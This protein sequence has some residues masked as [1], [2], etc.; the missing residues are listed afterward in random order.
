EFSKE[1]ALCLAANGIKAYRFES[2]RPTPE[3][4]F[5]VR[6]L[7]CI[8]GIVITASHN[9]KNHNGLKISKNNAEPVGYNTGL[10]DLEHWV[11]T[12][13]IA[14]TNKKGKIE[15]YN[16]MTEY[17][18]FLLSYKPDFDNLNIVVDC[19]NGMAS[20]LVDKILGEKPHYIN[21][22]MD[23]NFPG[24]EPN[25]LEMENI[26]QLQTAVQH[27]RADIGV[28]F[29]GDADRVMFVDENAQ[30]ISPDLMI[31]L[32]GHY[33]YEQKKLSGKVLFDIRTS[34]AVKEYLTQMGGEPHMWKVGRAYA[35]SKLKE[36]DGLFGGELA[37]HYY[38]KDFFYSDSAMLAVIL[39]LNIVAD[40][41]RK[42]I[43]VSQ[44]IAKIKKYENSGEINFKVQN[45]TK[46]MEMLK[47]YFCEQESCLHLYDFDGY[48]IEFA[49]WWFNIRP[50]N[51]EPYL[52][53]I[54][55]AKTKDL[56]NEKIHIVEQIITDNAQ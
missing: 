22:K 1:A 34:R 26:V 19:S 29:D 38:F 47:D 52:R 53:F 31:A 25:P 16:Y 20:L 35:A 48:R 49:D 51:T 11:E 18:Q 44:A 4:S 33:F 43:S 23:G 54:A 24:H 45:K 28:I 15:Q 7:G 21:K 39:M 46:I 50:S 17:E 13:P 56:L 5:A 6:E 10:K 14:V 40:F 37:G 41:K 2:L 42:N 9:P 55:E 32:L 36:I 30:F 8:A 12:E 3:L 27:C